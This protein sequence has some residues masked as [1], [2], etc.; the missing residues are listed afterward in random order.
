MAIQL[1]RPPIEYVLEDSGID[2]DHWHNHNGE[3][4][5]LEAQDNLFLAYAIG[6]KFI[7]SLA[8]HQKIIKRTGEVLVS[9]AVLATISYKIYEMI[10]KDGKSR[11]EIFDTFDPQHLNH[12]KNGFKPNLGPRDRSHIH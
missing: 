9:A 5:D 4:P 7:D 3:A 12:R 10:H 11:A 8:K 1:E 6:N 2:N